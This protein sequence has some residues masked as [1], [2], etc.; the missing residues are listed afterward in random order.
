MRDGEAE[1]AAPL[2]PQGGEE[3]HKTLGAQNR[4]EA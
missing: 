2:R 4:A 3:A 1:K